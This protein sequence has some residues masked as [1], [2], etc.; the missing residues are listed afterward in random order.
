MVEWL[1]RTALTPA[2][3][4]DLQ[5]RISISFQ[6]II[7]SFGQFSLLNISFHILNCPYIRIRVIQ[8]HISVWVCVCLWVRMVLFVFIQISVHVS[9]CKIYMCLCMSLYT[10]YWLVYMLLSSHLNLCVL[11]LWLCTMCLCVSLNIWNWIFL[12]WL[13]LVT[14]LYGSVLLLHWFDICGVWKRSSEHGCRE[15]VHYSHDVA[16]M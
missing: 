1:C 15:A 3:A 2:V 12:M 14:L 16:G 10:C 8:S 13:V 7:E 4:N 6:D 11:R 9:L 5:S